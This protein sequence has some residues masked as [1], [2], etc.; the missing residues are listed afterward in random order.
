MKTSAQIKVTIATGLA[1]FAMFF[2][3]GNIIFPLK[4]GSFSGEHI[5]YGL[6]A[7]VIAGVGVPFLGVFAVSLYEGDYW[8]FFNRL[9]K[10]PAFIVVT[11]L[12]LIIG[13]LFAAPRTE[14]ITYHTLLP[15]LPGILK[16]QYVFDALYFFVVF[17]FVA[18]QSRVVD[19]IG[20]LFSPIKIVSFSLLILIGMYTAMPLVPMHLSAPQVFGSSI[21][22]G[23]GTMDLLAAFFF[24]S[25]A[26]KNIVNKCEKINVTSRATLMKMMLAACLIGAL[27]ISVIY[28][29][30][31]FVAAS[32]A[33]ALQNV[34]TESLISQTANV[35]LGEYGALFVGICV[36]VA[37]LATGA[38]LAEVTTD[39]LFNTTFKQ[40]VPR[41]ICLIVVLGTMIF[42]SILGFDGI[43]K[44][45]GPILEV[46]YPALI[47]LCVVNIYMKVMPSKYTF[48]FRLADRVVDEDVSL[49]GTN[50]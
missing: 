48:K 3:A 2:G 6:L 44:I 42:M 37:C 46:I 49:A 22:L 21:T 17:L 24:C 7:F 10:V 4:V 15:A 23:Y 35:I 36:S 19:I 38:T 13:P 29:G 45:A 43:M 12:I 9:G 27:L 34:P 11:F 50:E 1:L 5:L 20:W 28:A 39:Y 31:I 14:V 33:Q 40:K 32:H 41:I 8:K 26:Y 47:L 18:R 30:F 25:V 16:N